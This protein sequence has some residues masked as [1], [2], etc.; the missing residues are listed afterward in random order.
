MVS[1]SP[2]VKAVTELL[3]SLGEPSFRVEQVL[4]GI[5]KSHRAEW[6]QLEEVPVKIRWRLKEKF[7]RYI[8]SFMLKAESEGDFAQKLLLKSFKDFAK[9]EAVSLQFHNHR[10]LCISSQVGCAFQCAFCATGKVGLKR[11][12]DA[13]EISDQVLSFMQRGQ[14]IDSVSLMGMGEP[15]ANPKSFDALRILTSPELFGLSPRRINVST[16]GVIPGIVKLTEEFPQVNVA[17]SLHS[18]FTEERNKLVP[19]NRMFPMAEVF[20]VLDRRIQKTGRR[21]WICYLL[22]KGQN[23]SRDHAKALVNLLQQRPKET[24]YLYHVNLLPYN[25]GRAVPETFERAEMEGIES[26]QQVLEKHR[27]SCSYRN[28]FG[29]GIEAACGQLYAGYENARGPGASEFSGSSQPPL[30]R[31]TS[32]SLSRAPSIEQERSEAQEVLLPSPEDVTEEVH[33]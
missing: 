33:W 32:P 21:V 9:V 13:D 27:I 16:V 15:L 24:R 25:T 29:H 10:S 20:D 17:F 19:L 11:Q 18:P 5:Y 28:S 2:R 7:G 4:K 12:L 26:F 30:L 22:L 14:K 8:N 23:D 6:Y 3:T 31:P 1:V